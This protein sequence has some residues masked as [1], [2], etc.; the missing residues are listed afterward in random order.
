MLLTYQRKHFCKMLPVMFCL[1]AA[2][3]TFVGGQKE[4][5]HLQVAVQEQN[6]FPVL[7]KF[8]ASQG[9]AAPCTH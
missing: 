4:L 8:P 5:K 7:P 9:A 6:I 3:V 2:Q 1:F